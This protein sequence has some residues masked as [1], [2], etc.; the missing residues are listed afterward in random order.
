MNLTCQ[1]P[2]ILSLLYFCLFSPA[3]A[4]VYYVAPDGSDNGSGTE[5]NPFATM[6]KGQTSASAGDTVWFR[7]GTYEFISSTAEDGVTLSKSGSSERRIH[8]WAYPGEKPVFDFSGL[9]AKLRNR[10]IHVTGSWLHLKGF[11]LRGVPQ[12][13]RTEHESWCVYNNGGSNNIYELL[14][15][16][17]NMG[18]GLFIV[19][20]GDNLVLNCDSHDNFDQYSSSN[21]T[22]ANA[23]GE[24]ADGF[25][26][27]CKDGHTGNVF[28]GCRAWWNT[29]DGWDFIHAREV[30][31]VENCWAWH[32]GYLP[33]TTNASGNGNGFKAGGYSLPPRDVPANPPQHTVRFCV[34]FLNRAQGFYANHHPVACYFYN[35]TAFNNRSSNFNM[36]GVSISG[37]DYSSANFGILRNNIAF[38]GTAI[39][40]GTGSG[41]DAA[42]NS[43]DLSGVSVSNADFLSVDTAGIYGPRKTDGSLPDITFLKLAAGSDAIDKGVDVGLP[44]SGKAP[45]LGAYETG[46]TGVAA[47]AV[48]Q[49]DAHPV[50]GFSGA[51]N[52]PEILIF[53][54]SG[55]RAPSGCLDGACTPSIYILKAAERPVR[56]VK[57]I[58]LK[59]LY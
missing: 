49:E 28:R 13:L 22:S 44:Y 25:G 18:P 27:H 53:N 54:L 45:D 8:Y 32:N 3:P 11:E 10:G 12:N 42:N 16:H 43:W 21:G 1:I 34:A 19:R 29:D 7:G 48:Y 23:P 56:T 47:A 5:D 39:A 4:K 20:G 36:L 24:N 17:H 55:S 50:S 51:F 15:M 9:T 57:S 41:V 38:T 6:A 40:N 35:N 2:F 46:M 37:S 59:K 33:G 31:I 14:D 30:V 52:Q 58:P 26:C